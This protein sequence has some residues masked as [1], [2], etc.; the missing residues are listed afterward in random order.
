MFSSIVFLLKKFIFTVNNGF[1]RCPH[2]N[3]VYVR[4]HDFVALHF[5]FG[6]TE[7][8]KIVDKKTLKKPVIDD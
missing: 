2:R 6:R 1:F 3:V 4:A 7:E 5:S 8:M